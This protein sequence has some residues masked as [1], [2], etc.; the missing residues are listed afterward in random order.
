MLGFRRLAGGNAPWVYNLSK[1]PCSQR[2]NRKGPKLT[3]QQQAVIIRIVSRGNKTADDAARLFSVHPATV[4]RLLSRSRVT[5]GLKCG[6][7]APEDCS[8]EAPTDPDMR[9]YRIRLFSPRL[10]YVTGEGRMRGCGKG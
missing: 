1:Y 5:A 2:E 6:R 8:S 3:P 10:R 4:A 7:V 9:D